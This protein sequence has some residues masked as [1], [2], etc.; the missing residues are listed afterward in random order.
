[1]IR[2][3]DSSGIVR[4]AT[5]VAHYERLPGSVV[6][7]LRTTVERTPGAEAVVD[8][9][10]P[11]VTYRE[12][13]DRSARVSGGLK[14][15]GIKPGDRVAI[16]LGNG[17]DWCLAFVGAQMAGAVVVP[18][19][20]R[21]SDSEVDFVVK[22]SGARFTIDVGRRLPDAK[23][24]VVEPA[25][26]GDL[27]AIFYTS[28]TTGF[29]KGAMITHEAFL[30]SS[31]TTMRVNDFPPQNTVRTLV[32]VPL[33]H[34]MGCIGQ[35]FPAFMG[36]AAAV[37]MANF[38]VR[39]F[40]RAI[41]EERID[42]LASVP[43]VYWL[44]LNHPHLRDLD[45]SAVR[46]VSYGGA[47]ISADLVARIGEGFPNARVGNGFGLTETAALTTFLPHEY[48][49]SRAETVGLAAPVV[50]LDMAEVDP[51]TGVG[52][53]LVRGP[54]VSKGY[55]N[56]PKETAETIVNGWLRTGD[57][58]RIDDAGFVQIVDRKK[59]VI[60]RGGENVYCIEVE[61]AIAAHPAVLEVAVVGVPDPV[62]G[63]KVGA[64][65]SAKPGMRLEPREIASFLRGRIA[66]FKVPE[67]VAL[68]PP[69][70]P[71]NAG[72][73]ILK[74]VLR[75]GTDWIMLAS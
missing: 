52:E 8:L 26:L 69:P 49:R 2:P 72:G 43:S 65:V 1:M 48:A 16:R 36:G 75:G 57:L 3:F 74:S 73:K 68:R 42:S 47:P 58:V 15:T 22:D 61:N 31:E 10:G 29:P 70:L 62:M 32:S 35:L 38:E 53:L 9:A 14:A 23:P 60:N 7:M 54:N 55:W 63:E 37:I 46:W 13:W 18:V 64:V 12:F 45:T 19:N 50:D 21:F 39:A 33:F 5:G 30:S 25:A 11:R 6:E 27:A 40:L 4:D 28:G 71:R 67:F 24:F 17:L 41:A 66:D 59:D 51:A 34:V 20:T 44:A 56:R